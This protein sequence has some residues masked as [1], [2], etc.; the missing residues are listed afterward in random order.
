MHGSRSASPIG[1][2]GLALDCI[3]RPD[4]S[5]LEIVWPSH[6]ASEDIT[7]PSLDQESRRAVLGHSPL[8][9][10]LEASTIDAVLAQAVVRRAV[11]G[12]VL[13]LR[14]QPSAGVFIIVTGRVR[15]G[16]VT[17]EGR[18]LTLAILGPGHVM[19][20]MSVLDGQDISAD[21]AAIEDCVLLFLERSRFLRILRGNGDL[22]L[23][24]MAVLVTRL[25]NSNAAVED[26]AIL[27]V[28]GRLASLLLRLSRDYGIRS[29]SGMRIQIRLSQKDIGAMIGASREKVNKQLRLWEQDGTLARDA[30]H[31]VVTETQALLMLLRQRS[32]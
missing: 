17:E 22:C 4:T 21:A 14:G 18:E 23:R 10:G 31:L 30:G 9:A 26:L 12:D 20:E 24:L 2:G 27:D 32:A 8:F 11:R 1:A 5:P 15:L 7:L 25:R 16:V 3:N 29:A 19:G 6:R 28:P 13:L